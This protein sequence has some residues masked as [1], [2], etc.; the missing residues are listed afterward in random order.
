LTF[1]PQT[2][3]ETDGTWRAVLAGSDLPA[4]VSQIT[5]TIKV[6]ADHVTGT[7]HVGR[8]PGDAP[9][10][11]GHIEGNRI[12]FTAIGKSPWWSSDNRGDD[13]KGL[14][15]LMF[16]GTIEGQEM[17]IDMVWDNVMLYGDAPKPREYRMKA[18]KISG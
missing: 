1:V 8:W 11:D 13:R 15:Q 17:E 18:R 2:T 6:D 12:Y 7:A 3:H 9:L 5:F 14:P 4:T 10:T 16:S